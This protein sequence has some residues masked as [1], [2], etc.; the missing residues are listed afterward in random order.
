MNTRLTKEQERLLLEYREAIE[1]GLR[2]KGHFS[3]V[4]PQ[5][6]P[7]FEE[8]EKNGLSV[9]VRDVE[10]EVIRRFLDYKKKRREQKPLFPVFSQLT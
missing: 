9:E 2:I 7:V 4:E 8:C 10:D 1:K 3:R 5:I 6:L